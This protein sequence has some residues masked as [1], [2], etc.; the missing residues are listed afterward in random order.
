[1][2]Y[3]RLEGVVP[4]LPSLEIGRLAKCAHISDELQPACV[5][6]GSFFLS[7][8]MSTLYFP[9]IRNATFSVT[10]EKECQT[11]VCLA[12]LFEL[13]GTFVSQDICRRMVGM[14]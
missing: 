8:M 14:G 9:L 4:G 7:K 12:K 11:S 1:M 10:S 2:D 13:L 5:F 3:P 6:I